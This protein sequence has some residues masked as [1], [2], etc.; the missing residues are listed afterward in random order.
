[1][2]ASKY[3]SRRQQRGLD[4]LGDAFL[5]GAGPLPSFSASGCASS[6]DSVL[7]YLPESDRNDLGLLLG[8][9][10]LLPSPFT[11]MLLWLLDRSGSLPTGLGALLRFARIGVRGLVMSL[12]WGHPPVL[13]AIEYD[14]SVVLD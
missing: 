3:L 10:G 6:V 8:I 7:A 1:M 12:Y 11:G 13:E 14:V 2:P 9:L 5:P 4:R